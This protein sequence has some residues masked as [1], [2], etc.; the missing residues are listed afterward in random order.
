MA[1]LLEP[2]NRLVLTFHNDFDAPVGQVPC[3][4]RYTEGVGLLA[5][6]IAEPDTLHAAADP[7]MT[8][9]NHFPHR[10]SAGPARGVQA[11]VRLAAPSPRPPRP[12]FLLS[13]AG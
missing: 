4:P 3:P 13:G 11:P 2:G 12:A 5:E 10:T 6:R 1:P 9:D 7:Q 8:T